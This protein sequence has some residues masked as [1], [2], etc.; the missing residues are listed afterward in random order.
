M[1]AEI[2]SETTSCAVF[3]SSPRF[4][5][6]FILDIKLLGI[7]HN[8]CLCVLITDFGLVRTEILYTERN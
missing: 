8:R 2:I 1:L 3:L 4:D 6:D 5:Q 7:D